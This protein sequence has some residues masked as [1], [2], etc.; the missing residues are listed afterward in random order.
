MSTL[1]EGVNLSADNLSIMENKI[2]LSEMNTIYFRNLIGWV[3]RIS[4]NLYENVYFVAEPNSKITT[5]NYVRMFGQTIPE[6]SLSITT[7]PNVLKKVEKQ[8]VV[9]ILKSGK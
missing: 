5:D 7:D 2:F 8:Y 1:L 9:D 4:F 6:Q 3:G